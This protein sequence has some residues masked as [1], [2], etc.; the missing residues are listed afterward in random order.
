M[1][2]I[3][4]L[5]DLHFGAT[6]PEALDALAGV[7]V[8]DGIESVIV[9]GD[10]TQAG[11]K[12]EFEAAA[13][14]FDELS[15]PAIAIPGNHDTPVFNLFRRF[16][17]PWSRF[18]EYTGFDEEPIE[19]HDGYIFAGLNSARRMRLSLDWS[20]GNLNQGQLDRIRGAFDEAGDKLKLCGFHHPIVALEDAGSA[21]RAIIP[22]PERVLRTLVDAEVDIVMTGHVHRARI[23][24][25]GTEDRS[26]ILSQAGTAVSTRLRGEPASYNVITAADED[27]VR[28]SVHR[29]SES[30]FS[31]ESSKT[32]A[33]ADTGWS[34]T[35]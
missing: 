24:E 11:R 17:E 12:D 26:F 3:A 35:P 31:I 25:V 27:Q 7:L 33:R 23:T 6:D 18:S 8:S 22:K 15:L 19:D 13:D 5:S 2:R 34:E 10:L 20:T 16:F 32:F 29:W 28:V 21:G 4:H 30:G 9:T 14:W 1:T